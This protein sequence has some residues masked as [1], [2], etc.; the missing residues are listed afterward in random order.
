MAF[1]FLVFVCWS[2][3][4][5]KV[6]WQEMRK[7]KKLVR[8]IHNEHHDLKPLSSFLEE[9]DE[10]ILLEIF[11]RLPNYRSAILFSLI[12]R[13]HSISRFISHHNEHKDRYPQ[14]CTVIFCRAYYLGF[15]NKHFTLPRFQPI[16]KLSS[17]ESMFLRQTSNTATNYLDFLHSPMVIRASCNDLLLVSPNLDPWTH[18]YYICNPITRQFYQL[19]KIPQ[20][21]R[22]LAC[23]GQALICMPNNEF[24]IV[25]LGRLRGIVE[26]GAISSIG[27][28]SHNVRI[29]SSKTGTWESKC[30]EYPEPREKWCWVYWVEMI[31]CPI[32]GVVYWLEQDYDMDRVLSLD[33][34]NDNKVGIIDFPDDYWWYPRHAV[35]QQKRLIRGGIKGDHVKV[36]SQ[37]GVVSGELWLLQ[38]V[39]TSVKG[40]INLKVWR[41]NNGSEWILVED[42]KNLKDPIN[43]EEEEFV[44]GFTHPLNNETLILVNIFEYNLTDGTVEIIGVLQEYINLSEFAWYMDERL[45]CIPVKPPA[46][47]TTLPPRNRAFKPL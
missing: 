1:G 39:S 33:L 14:P 18:L 36:K 20:T 19:P 5:R 28:Y 9:V 25:V 30:L 22:F 17:E 15:L 24:K 43:K 29:F 42:R 21:D 37:I 11:V 23:G 2:L 16:C 26:E 46:W 31:M 47:L 6:S 41:L 13:P 34:R 10:D 3:L 45:V 27:V 12:S 32:S 7:R 4:G 40:M 8:H 44:G 38:F 35:D